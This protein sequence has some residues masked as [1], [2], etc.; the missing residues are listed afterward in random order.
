MNNVDSLLVGIDFTNENDVGVL[1]VGKRR[2][3]K[4]D[5][6]NVFQGEE[7]V[8]LYEKLM[9]DSSAVEK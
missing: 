1:V 7:A 2:N 8:E 5:I 6:V 4:T 9:G 3:G